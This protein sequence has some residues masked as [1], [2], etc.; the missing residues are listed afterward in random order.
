MGA[1]AAT[2]HDLLVH[3][4]M[5]RAAWL[6]AGL[7][8]GCV[9]GPGPEPPSSGPGGK[10]D[11]GQDEGGGWAPAPPRDGNLR[12][13]TFNIRNFPAV[14]PAEGQMTPPISYLLETDRDALL[15]LLAALDFD[16]LAL[17][18]IRDPDA[19]VAL[20]EDLSSATGR[21]YES[22]FAVNA[23]GNDQHT[24]LVVSQDA[25]RI[26]WTREHAEVDVS[27]TLR[28]AL[29]ARIE[30]VAESGADFTAMVLHLASGDSSKR[31]DLR[32]QQATA[33]AAAAATE[34]AETSDSDYLVLGDMNTAR[35]DDELGALDAAF[36]QE[37]GL[38]RGEN[39]T[40]CTSYWVKKSTNPL[41]RPST[42]DHAYLSSFEERDQ[43]VPIL[44]GA[45]CPV[46]HCEAFESRHAESGG[47]FY[48]I[49]DH[50][51]LYFEI[52]DA[53][54]D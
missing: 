7:L 5:I 3:R 41:V 52:T 20:L 23:S 36:A 21:A 12:I 44:A 2:A 11:M 25:L 27:G 48:S 6:A 32:V 38:A 33:A 34:I 18:E 45:H 50:C 37:T 35:G 51:P 19:F 17:Q 28:P 9:A 8:L 14:P 53:D 46:H 40:G 16:L 30:S 4:A 31:A 39:A 49:S 47:S 54:L 29:S 15:E 13:V 1:W 43:T 24:G 10:A 22:R 26:A 42:L